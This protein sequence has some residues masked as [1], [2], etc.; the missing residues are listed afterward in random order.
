MILE[1]LGMLDGMKV[2]IE[3]PVADSFMALVGERV[4]NRHKGDGSVFDTHLSVIDFVQHSLNRV[5]AAGF[6]A[7]DGPQNDDAR[8]GP[9]TGIA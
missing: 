9:G 8:A 5:R 1:V 4:R 6:I 7:M 2:A 3:I